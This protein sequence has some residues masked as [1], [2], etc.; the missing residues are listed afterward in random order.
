LLIRFKSFGPVRRLLG[1]QVIE[2]DVPDGS[3]VLQVIQ[4]VVE[5]GGEGL[6]DLVLENESI[7]GNLIVMLNKRDVA[8]LGGIAIP[9]AEGDEV[10]LL[11]HVQGG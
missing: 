7:G 3:T 1:H 4:K 9:V 5:Q 11:P 6:R 2:V 10:A 8:T